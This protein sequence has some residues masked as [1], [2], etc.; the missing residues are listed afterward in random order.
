MDLFSIV[1]P[2][3]WTHSIVLQAAAIGETFCGGG[4]SEESVGV[5][6]G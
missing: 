2:I 1:D 4:A 6:E 3:G 5:S